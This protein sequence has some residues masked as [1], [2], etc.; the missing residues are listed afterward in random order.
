[1]ILSRP[2]SLSPLAASSHKV[3]TD[4]GYLV[5]E[6]QSIGRVAFARQ[7]IHSVLI[8]CSVGSLTKRTLPKRHSLSL[9]RAG[10]MTRPQLSAENH[11]PSP[12]DR[13]VDRALPKHWGQLTKKEN[14]PD[15]QSLSSEG[16]LN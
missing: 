4:G 9:G 1:M 13:C 14:P 3:G 11:K 7:P 16:F 5:Y 2:L 8:Q 10:S 15:E 12:A 6:H